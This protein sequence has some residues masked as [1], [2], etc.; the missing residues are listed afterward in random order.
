LLEADDTVGRVV[1]IDVREP[2]FSTRNLEFYRMDVRSPDLADVIAGC[3]AIVHLAAVNDRDPVQTQDVIVGGI[4]AVVG[5]AGAVD[6]RKLVFTSAADVYGAHADADRPLT[7]ESAVRPGPRGYG[8]ANAEAE[9]VARAFAFEHRDA[10]VTVLRLAAVAGPSMPVP[11]TFPLPNAGAAPV[12]ALHEDDAARAVGHVLN[13]MLPGTF[14]VCADDVLEYPGDMLGS[15]GA[16]DPARRLRDA[17]SRVGLVPQAGAPRAFPIVMSNDRLRAGGFAP[18]FSSADALRAGA[19]AQR[20]WV[21]VGGV[22]VRPR[23]VAAAIGSV[24]ALAIGRA[25]RAV[26]ARRAKATR[27]GS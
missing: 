4:R 1:G 22:R 15:P 13:T 25:A 3:D 16:G 27:F 10:V 24:A 23:W 9:D 5:A 7:E 11:A 8:A 12:Q 6:A 18:S 26:S 17:A 2:D 19:E 21:S 20:G 14:N